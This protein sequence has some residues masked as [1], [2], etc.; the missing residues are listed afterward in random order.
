M[1][2]EEDVWL[3]LP[4][5]AALL[6]VESIYS[7]PSMIDT[8]QLCAGNHNRESLYIGT[9]HNGAPQRTMAE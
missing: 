2:S 6:Y 9:M 4:V 8:P 3:R 1:V 7:L 5:L